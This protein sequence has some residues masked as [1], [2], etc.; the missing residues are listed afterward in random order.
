MQESLEK[1][2]E[3]LSICCALASTDLLPVVDDAVVIGDAA[4]LLG[5]GQDEAEA[6]SELVVPD[7][8]DRNRKW[9]VGIHFEERQLVRNVQ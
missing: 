1:L 4:D 3:G 9:D 6:H 8:L 5:T 2:C 7:Q